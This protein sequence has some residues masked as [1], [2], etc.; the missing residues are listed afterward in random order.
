MEERVK[1]R[2]QLIVNLQT[3]VFN[4]MAKWKNDGET[5]STCRQSVDVGV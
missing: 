5:D 4:A 2:A 1:I 3:A